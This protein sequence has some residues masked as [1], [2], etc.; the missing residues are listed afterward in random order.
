VFWCLLS[1]GIAEPFRPT[2][3]PQSFSASHIRLKILSYLAEVRKKKNMIGQVKCIIEAHKRTALYTIKILL[4]AIMSYMP[5]FLV[6]YSPTILEGIN[7]N[8]VPPHHKACQRYLFGLPFLASK[9]ILPSLFYQP[10]FSSGR[11][12]YT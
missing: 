5:I 11:Q 9:A 10:S 3:K 2:T 7:G 8:G 12:S 6:G 4:T 1:F